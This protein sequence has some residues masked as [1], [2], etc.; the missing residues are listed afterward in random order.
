[1][2]RISW[3]RGWAGGWLIAGLAVAL[4]APEAPAKEAPA[5]EAPAKGDLARPDA[6]A[7]NVVPSSVAVWLQAMITAIDPATRAVTL[8]GVGGGALTVIA[9]PSVRLELLKV[10]DLVDL[11]YYRQVA[12]RIEKPGHGNGAPQPETPEVAEMLARPAQAPGGVAV[13]VVR[14][15]GTVVG[16]DPGRHTIDLVEPSGGGVYT[17]AAA[18]KE[19]REV[20]RR[21]KVGDTVTVLV[22]R[23][24][25][26][27]ITP[28][29]KL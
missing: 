21:L 15:S 13:S 28:A 2:R 1:M 10:G 27:E 22:S 4:P 24:L 3:R 29:K 5:K 20:L 7:A 8:Q 18:D 16:I 9:G 12:F 23:A 11:H 17:V 26:V 25:A 6:G 19:R 14:L